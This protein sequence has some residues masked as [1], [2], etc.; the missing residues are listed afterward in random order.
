MDKYIEI[1]KILME[2]NPLSVIGPA[3]TDEY[4]GLIP[5]ILAQKSELDLEIFLKRTMSEQYGVE[6]GDSDIEEEKEFQSLIK[7]IGSIL[8]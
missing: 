2:W 5:S 7:R 4:I 3:L 8:W 6:Y 1:N